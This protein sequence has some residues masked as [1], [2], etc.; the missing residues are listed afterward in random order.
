MDAQSN[1][2][3]FSNRSSPDVDEMEIYDNLPPFP[4][5]LVN[6]PPPSSASSTATTATVDTTINL[7]DSPESRFSP[8]RRV[9]IYF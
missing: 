8:D 9:K 2:S 6:F 7:L 3:G 5:A 1:F 4:R